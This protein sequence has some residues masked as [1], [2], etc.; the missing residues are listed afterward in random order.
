MDAILVLLL[1]TI[2][3]LFS[4]ISIADFEQIHLSWVPDT[5]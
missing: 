5:M 1:L 4:I 2:S 3:H